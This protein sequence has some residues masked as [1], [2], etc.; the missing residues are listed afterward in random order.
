MFNLIF[1][2][3]IFF[4]G[5]FLSISLISGFN[6]DTH[7]TI[8]DMDIDIKFGISQVFETRHVRRCNITVGCFDVLHH[9]HKEL[10]DILG[11]SDECNDYSPRGSARP[12]TVAFV[13]DNESMLRNKGVVAEDSLDRRMENVGK[14]IDHVIPVYDTDPSD[15]L[16]KYISA[17]IQS[18]QFNYIR[19]N[20]RSEFPGKTVIDEFHIPTR[21][22]RNCKN[23]FHI[24]KKLVY[25]HRFSF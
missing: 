1:P 13:H 7:V 12:V 20:D 9:G 5:F 3:K 8:I 10:F 21:L 15:V 16:R 22:I 24:I 6:L 14:Y 19:G 4:I 25:L 2:Q 11:N 23:K 18:T 17:N